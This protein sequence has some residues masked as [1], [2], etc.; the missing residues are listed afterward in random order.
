MKPKGVKIREG[1]EILYG[2]H[3]ARG[4]L[5]RTVEEVSE[6]VLQEVAISGDFQFYPKD[7]L[8]MMEGSLQKTDFDE[9]A[10][11]SKVEEFYDKRKVEVPGVEPED[12][13]KAIV[14]ANP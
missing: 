2:L 8:P 13:T 3:K 11:E 14:E 4:G 6:K 5:I 7:D 9:K 10:I 1:V 12:F